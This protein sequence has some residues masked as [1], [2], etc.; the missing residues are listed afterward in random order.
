MCCEKNPTKCI[1]NDLI[2]H[3]IRIKDTYSEYPKMQD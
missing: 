2:L 3:V 1:L